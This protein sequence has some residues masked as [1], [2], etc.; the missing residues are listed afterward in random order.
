MTELN[1]RIAVDVGSGFTKYTDGHQENN[2]PSLVCPFNNQGDFGVLNDEVVTFDGVPYLTG[3]SAYTFGGKANDRF[4]TLTEDWAGSKG[5]LALIYRVIGNLGITTGKIQLATG[6]PQSLFIRD[7]ARVLNEL[8]RSHDFVFQCL[9]HSVDIEAVVI[10]QAA[11]ALFSAAANDDAILDDYVGCIDV[12]TYTTGFSVINGMQFVPRLS[13][14]IPVGMSE[15][16]GKLKEELKHKGFVT[17]D[18]RY[19]QI[20]SQKKYRHRG[21]VVD[22][23][24]LINDLAASVAGKVIDEINNENEK[25][26]SWN[27]AG[28]M[29]V[30]ITGGGAEHFAPALK[31]SIQH[32]ELMDDSFYSVAKGMLIYLEN[33]LG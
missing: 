30:F 26:E 25:K 24:S 15:L 18:S 33:K 28:E 27:G 13:G 4:S 14:G 12:G 6:I 21:Q 32:L 17:D 2:L 19:E 11:A 22:I 1:K 23:T 20:C 3:K 29:R 31:G 16:H 5:W 10:P 8:N 9:E 7:K